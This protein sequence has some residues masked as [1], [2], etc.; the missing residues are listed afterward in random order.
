MPPAAT[1][2][3]CSA[4]RCCRSLPSFWYS[5]WVTTVGLSAS[6][7]PWPEGPRREQ[8]ETIGLRQPE[9]RLSNNRKEKKAMKISNIEAILVRAP[10]PP[11]RHFT[12]ETG[13]VTNQEALLVR[14]TTEGGVVGYGETTVDHG[15]R[16]SVLTQVNSVF[17]PMLKGQ[18][19]H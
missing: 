4:C 18:S 6:K 17:A 15:A 5:W 9:G 3:R 7:V 13:L 19:A 11:E 12:N 14:V 8:L 16:E 1:T 10:I 2:S